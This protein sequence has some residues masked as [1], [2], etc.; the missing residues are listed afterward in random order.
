MVSWFVLCDLIQCGNEN[1]GF[2][3]TV[4]PQIMIP[5][6]E[7][8][9]FGCD[10]N[11]HN[12]EYKFLK[13][14]DNYRSLYRISKTYLSFTHL[15]HWFWWI[16]GVLNNILHTYVLK[17]I[18]DLLLSKWFKFCNVM[19]KNWTKEN[20]NCFATVNKNYRDDKNFC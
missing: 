9:K 4:K 18:Y 17:W 11:F 15:G 19:V 3:Y 5:K 7:N 13:L 14:L 10:R 12:T 6:L 16:V 8:P 2:I 20:Q 1:T